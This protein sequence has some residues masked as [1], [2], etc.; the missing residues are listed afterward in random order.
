MR[1]FIGSISKTPHRL[2]MFPTRVPH[3]SHM[4]PTVSTSIPCVFHSVSMWG[5]PVGTSLGQ[6]KKVWSRARE[7]AVYR[8]YSPGFVL[9]APHDQLT[10]WKRHGQLPCFSPR[11]W[12]SIWCPLHHAEFISRH[13][14]ICDA[15]TSRTPYVKQLLRARKT[16]M[17]RRF[18]HSVKKNNSLHYTIFT[19]LCVIYNLNIFCTTFLD[20]MITCKIM[21]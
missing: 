8:V 12:L 3:V 20:F 1:F 4:G 21:S 10:R 17:K 13:K 18:A 19:L 11:V 7:T 6:D 14:L 5:F 9:F 2:Y 16:S 15:R